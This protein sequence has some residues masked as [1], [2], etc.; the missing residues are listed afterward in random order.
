VTVFG[1]FGPKCPVNTWEKA[2]TETRMLWLARALG[3]K[4]CLE[5]EIVL[6]TDDY[7]PEAYSGSFEDVRRMFNS[8]CAYMHVGADQLELE[9]CEDV[10]MFGLAGQYDSEGKKTIRV[11]R[12]QTETPM[13]LV[14]TLAHEIAHEILLGGGLLN[15]DESDHEEVTDLLPVYLGLGIFAANSTVQEEYKTSGLVSSWKIGKHGYLPA[16]IL[17]YALALCCHVRGEGYPEWSKY[18]RTDAVIALEESLQYIERTNDTLFG[19]E[20]VQRLNHTLTCEEAVHLLEKGTASCRL[21]T[22]W[23]IRDAKLI[24]P[25]MHRAVVRLLDDKD[26]HIPGTAAQI[27]PLFGSHQSV[28]LPKLL[29]LL[30]ASRHETRAEIAMALGML[31]TQPDEVIPELTPLLGDSREDVVQNAARAL[32]QFGNQA[33]AAVP[34]LV[35]ALRRSLIECSGYMG[36][37]VLGALTSISDDPEQALRDHL[38]EDDPE[39]L[40]HGLRELGAFTKRSDG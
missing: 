36:D 6:P 19:P 16:R 29:N 17:S 5:A 14:K 37:A 8:V 22:L 18:L 4:R 23:T 40:S 34:H 25:N 30:R 28:P 7:F 10:Q 39:L 12:S 21:A 26:P 24:S 31:N 33:R 9:I 20:S 38:P 15:P 2:W 27:L 32:G 35:D 11:A 3:I 13:S 1:L